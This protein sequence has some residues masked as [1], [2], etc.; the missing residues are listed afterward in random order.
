M[1]MSRILLSAVSL[2]QYYKNLVT[3]FSLESACIPP[4]APQ[5]EKLS[6]CCELRQ[7]QELPLLFSL[8]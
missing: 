1:H 7:S 3:S 6:Q 2:L 5:P 4:L 8:S